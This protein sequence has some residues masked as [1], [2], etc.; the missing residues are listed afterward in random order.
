MQHLLGKVLRKLIEQDSISSMLFWG[1]PGFT[2]LCAI[3]ILMRWCTG[4]QGCWKEE[5][6]L[7]M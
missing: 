2:S 3:P 4:W 6:I 5:R 7:S 1:P